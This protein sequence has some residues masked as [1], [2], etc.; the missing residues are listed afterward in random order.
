[1]ALPRAIALDI[2]TAPDPAALARLAGTPPDFRPSTPEGVAKL[3]A[4]ALTGVGEK[5]SVEFI[6]AVGG[7]GGFYE[8]VDARNSAEMFRRVSAAGLIK[9]KVKV[10]PADL[11]TL[12]EGIHSAHDSWYAGLIRRCSFDPWLGRVVSVALSDGAGGTEGVLHLGEYGEAP[13]ETGFGAGQLGDEARMLR[14]LWSW[15]A[16]YFGEH[17]PVLV[18]FNG[19]AFDSYFL[20]I[21]SAVCGVEIPWGLDTSRNRYEPVCD[22]YEYLTGWGRHLGEKGSNTLLAFARRLGITH[23]TKEEGMDGSQVAGLVE[24]GRWDEIARYNLEDARVTMAI[25]ERF[26][27]QLFPPAR[28]T[29]RRT[30]APAQPARAPQTTTATTAARRAA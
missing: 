26:R 11:A 27:T 25:F 10:G 1:M 4:D 9:A 3:F 22:L 5:T 21:R 30:A 2:E 28:A 6:E 19:I 20:R 17:P 16:S 18:T 8:L 24:A 23:E 15:L 29:T 12:I 14:D 13:S 7:V